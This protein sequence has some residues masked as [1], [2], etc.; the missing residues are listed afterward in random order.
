MSSN[1]RHAYV[2]LNEHL[3]VG[4]EYARMFVHLILV[5]LNV[6]ACLCT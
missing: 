2:I 1:V 3:C 6:G 5:I 4:S